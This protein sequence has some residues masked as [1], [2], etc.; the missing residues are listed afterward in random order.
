MNEQEIKETAIQQYKIWAKENRERIAKQITDISKLEIDDN[1]VSVFMAGSPGAGKTESSIQLIKNFN[2]PILRIDTDV[3][4]EYFKDMGYDGKNSHIYQGAASLITERVHDHAL[5]NKLS[6]VF[7][8]TFSNYT[9]AIENIRRS[10]KKQRLIQILYVYQEP[11][12]A[13]EFT[14][15]R[16]EVEGRRILRDNFITQ[17]F[18]SRESVQKIKDELGELV[19]VDII[20]KDIDNSELEYIRN[21]NNISNHIK[22]KYTLQ[23]LDNILQ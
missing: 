2:K 12:L 6:F 5:K 15:K 16:E 19:K 1:P 3:Y 23:S 21:V 8:G 7:D 11:L 18:G 14:K 4:R 22:T 10:L 20:I 13:W 17:F 9:K